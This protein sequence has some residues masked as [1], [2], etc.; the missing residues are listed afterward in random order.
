MMK[1]LFLTMVL[2]VI[3]GMVQGCGTEPKETT[4]GTQNSVKEG[5]TFTFVLTI[6]GEEKRNQDFPFEEGDLLLDVMAN[7]LEVIEENG[8]IVAI[9]GY[10]NDNQAEKYL[11]YYVNGEMPDIGAAAYELKAGD[12]IEWKLEKMDVE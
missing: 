8:L 3:L 1:K 5:V 4:T 7:E 9:D 11:M 6:D 12:K 2:V 10:K